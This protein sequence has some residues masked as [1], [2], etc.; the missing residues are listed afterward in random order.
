MKRAFRLTE[1]HKPHPQVR[2]ARRGGEGDRGKCVL[3]GEEF[4]L[5]ECN[6]S[7]VPHAA[8]QVLGHMPLSTHGREPALVINTMQ[9]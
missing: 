7:S 1:D 3:R 2:G 4:R 9:P 6:S 5:I 8:T